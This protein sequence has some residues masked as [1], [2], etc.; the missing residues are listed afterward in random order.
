MEWR[1]YFHHP[2]LCLPVIRRRAAE[3]LLDTLLWYGQVVVTRGWCVSWNNSAPSKEA[4][5]NSARRL[6]KAGLI[7]REGRGTTGASLILTED[8]KA[9]TSESFRAD[10][11]W[12][13]KWNGL[14]YVLVYDIPE[15]RRKF[16]DNLRRFLARLRMGCLQRSVWVSAQDIR[17][18]YDDLVHAAKVEYVSFLFEATTVLG[19][20][21]QDVVTEAWDFDRIDRIQGWYREVFEH[22]LAVVG[23]GKLEAEDLRKL[24]A[25]EI[26][27]Y[28][29]A[30]WQDPLLPGEL[31][32][33]GYRGY[34][35]FQ[36][37]NRFVRAI[38]RHL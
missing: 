27:A 5:Y 16:R 25:E 14:W 11:F 36:L 24:A 29:S 35:V 38:K 3:L 23:S 12:K 9:R 4:F 2:D 34:D 30:M 22:N 18:E 1:S 37:H 17:P 21:P 20:S 10:R 8:G 19:R 15:D 7:V 26:E 6:A 13:R 31:L 33:A 28:L 32:P